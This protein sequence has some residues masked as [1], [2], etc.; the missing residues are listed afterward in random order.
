MFWGELLT[1]MQYFGTFF[2]MFFFIYCHRWCRDCVQLQ[3]ELF[4]PKT[5]RRGSPCECHES[6]TAIQL[7]KENL[8][9]GMEWMISLKG[10]CVLANQP[11]QCFD[12]FCRWLL[13]EINPPTLEK[14][15]IPS[16]QLSSPPSTFVP[17]PP[18]RFLNLGRSVY[19]CNFASNVF[20]QVTHL[21][22]IRVQSDLVLPQLRFFRG[23]FLSSSVSVLPIHFITS[24][25]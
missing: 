2:F 19:Q 6:K 8:Y 7:A 20:T 22:G 12:D 10:L 13:H 5:V 9:K 11:D 18:L 15:W 14:L 21:A 4:K 3:I 17:E 1:T 16:V 24:K 23:N 25:R